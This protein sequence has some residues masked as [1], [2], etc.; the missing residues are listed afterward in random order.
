L[1]GGRFWPLMQK[2]LRQIKR[3]RRLVVSLVIPPT[4]Q[5]ILFGFALNPQVTHLR[6][7]VADTS[8]T[9][10]SRALV[11]AFI[12]S[13][14]FVVEQ[15]F[16]SADELGAALSRGELD[17]GLV[18]PPDYARKR[19][20]RETAD[21]Q[22][23]IDAVNSNTAA[24]AGGYAARTIAALNQKLAL[25][26][27]PV[28]Q[29]APANDA[30]AGDGSTNGTNANGSLAASPAVALNVAPS[31][32]ARAVVT[33]RIT[34]L[35]NPG[36][37]NS[38]FIVTGT[39]GTLLVLNGSIVASASM[40]IEKEVGTIEQLLMTPAEATEIITA[41]IA[42]LFL[43]LCGDVLLALAVGRVV[44]GVPVRGSL[45]LL[46]C[47]GALCVFAG[48]GIGTFLATF[49]RSQQQAQLMGFFVN[50]PLAMLSGA[51]TP[52]EGM[53]RWLQPF[54]LANPIRHFAT[55][56]RGVMLKGTGLAELYPNFLVL[57]GMTPREMVA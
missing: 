52:I 21:V 47:A 35:Y 12:E 39:L 46:F 40:V 1:V 8:R 32:L 36:L 6:L 45:L 31:P 42:P 57:L 27:P 44:F 24:I 22:L 11:S 17:A 2:E 13:Q 25:A 20:R 49:T 10:E 28:G 56:S 43:L 26:A 19:A 34:L 23:L 33:P 38:W 51:T 9:A 3:N 41:K 16:T 54:T 7:G 37:L 50:P 15:Q 30:S 48:I 5:L 55:I 29:P 14:A 4:L 53:P 18:I